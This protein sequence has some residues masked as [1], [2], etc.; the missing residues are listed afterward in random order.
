MSKVKVVKTEEDLFLEDEDQIKQPKALKFFENF[1]DVEFDFKISL[2]RK[3]GKGKR[4]FITEYFNEVPQYTSIQK[5]YGGGE[6]LLFANKVVNGRATEQLDTVTI[7]L[8]HNPVTEIQ[9]NNNSGNDFFSMENMQ[10]LAMIKQIF[11]GGDSGQGVNDVMLKM[12]EMQSQSALKMM[13]LQQSSDRRMTDLMNNFNEKFTSLI[14]DTQKN[15]PAITEMTEM[16]SFFNEISGGKGES[17]AIDKLLDYAPLLM[18]QMGNTQQP[19]NQVNV[20]QIVPPI[21]K[22]REQEINDIIKKIPKE[23]QDKITEENKEIIIEQFFNKYKEDVTRQDVTDIVT[24]ILN[25]RRV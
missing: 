2:Y 1:S 16:F 17:S 12:V 4:V 24:T 6:Y 8:E 14:M 5:L 23:Y 21:K 3:D 13:E 10:K 20:N 22:S 7:N 19:V 11:G 25:R 15:K 18:S 9:P